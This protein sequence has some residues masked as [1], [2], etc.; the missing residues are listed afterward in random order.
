MMEDKIK[1]DLEQSIKDSNN[2]ISNISRFYSKVN[3]VVGKEA[4]SNLRG[5]RRY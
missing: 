4:L 5:C 2:I 3:K 1:K